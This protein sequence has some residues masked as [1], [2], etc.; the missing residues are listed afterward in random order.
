MLNNQFEKL[1]HAFDTDHVNYWS[2]LSRI[3]NLLIIINISMLF[4]T[5]L[6]AKGYFYICYSLVFLGVVGM[7][8]LVP[9]TLVRRLRYYWA[10][11]AV[12]FSGLY[13]L[14]ASVIYWVKHGSG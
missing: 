14:V 7:G 13:F 3:N 9:T 6:V 2:N 11:L 5:G 1:Q 10:F 12:E 8:V 4:L